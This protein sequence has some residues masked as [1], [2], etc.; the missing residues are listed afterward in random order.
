MLSALFMIALASAAPAVAARAPAA[1]AATVTSLP[2]PLATPQFR[3]YGL[4][5]GLP[6]A[7]IYAVAQ[8]HDGYMWFATTSGLARYDGVAFEV[9]RHDVNNPH[10]LPNNQIYTLFV[11]RD[12][13][14]WAGGVS[15]G[16]SRYDPAIGGF[17]HWQHV[18]A[19]PASLSHDEVWSITQTP[20][21]AI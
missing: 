16:L 11:D 5:D 10:S 6:G 8:D 18:D 15:S 19:D 14:V 3:R 17:R 4:V 12:G 21:G 1:P 7:M 9:F 20:D 2:A 13:R